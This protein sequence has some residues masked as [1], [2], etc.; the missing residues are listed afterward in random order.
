[1]ESVV[2]TSARHAGF[3]LIELMIVMVLVAI[4][5][6]VGVP[7]FQNLIREN[8]L[9]TQANELVSTLHFARSEAIKRRLPVTVCRTATGTA[10]VTGGTP[11]WETGWLV[12]VDDNVNTVVD[13]TDNDG[14]FNS[15]EQLLRSVVA[16]TTSTL[17]STV[18]GTND[19]VRFRNN[20][21]LNNAG[22]NFRLC[23]ANTADPA[24]G[25]NIGINVTGNVTTSI[26][27]PSC[28]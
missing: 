1:M 21:L 9:A 7:S 15:T 2:T 8:R 6:T 23:D 28:P 26:N 20:G 19:T 24:S 5:L 12:F 18:A 10:C 17:R 14:L 27:V 22:G 13:V 4:F 3:T 25:R 16:N 11:S